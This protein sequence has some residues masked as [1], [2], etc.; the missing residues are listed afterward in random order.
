MD[1]VTDRSQ[2]ALSLRWEEV[3]NNIGWCWRWMLCPTSGPS[4]FKVPILVRYSCNAD[5]LHVRG[6]LHWQT[7]KRNSME[8]L[9]A[10]PETQAA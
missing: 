3:A 6:A 1:L 9:I 8:V 4:S 5:T 10:K 2:L 7:V